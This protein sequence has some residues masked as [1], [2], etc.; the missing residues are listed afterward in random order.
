MQG[1]IKFV[2]CAVSVACRD[3]VWSAT[4]KLFIP[5][6]A[7]AALLAFSFRVEAT[8]T[9][10][11]E[12]L[13]DPASDAGIGYS[14]WDSFVNSASYP[15]VV[16]SNAAPGAVDTD[17]FTAT[18]S[19]NG[20]GSVTGGGDRIYNGIAASSGAFNLT[21]DGTVTASIDTITLQIKMTAPDESTGLTIL[22]FFTVTLNGEGGSVVQTNFGT[23]ETVGSQELGVI[24]YTWS[25][26]SLGT[27]DSLAFSITS[28]A[29]GHVSV[30]A[31]RVDASA[32]PEPS[33]LMSGAI[34]LS[35][36]VWMSRRRKAALRRLK[37][38]ESAGL[39]KIS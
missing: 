28:P 33:A 18:L 23:G 11:S 12:P 36:C 24:T 6:V 5:L 20:G 39:E 9:G 4:M 34:G 15:N 17:L 29:S 27:G 38:R 37:A 13:G 10:L 3:S 30:D 25:G 16:F 35:I 8:T 19:S 7:G 22:T 1:V 14:L 31:L 32:V 21:I 2:Q 26:L